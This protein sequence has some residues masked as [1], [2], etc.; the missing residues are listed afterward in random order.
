VKLKTYLIEYNT[1]KRTQPMA[2]F[3]AEKKEAYN[4]WAR[5]TD[6]AMPGDS[7]TLKKNGSTIASVNRGEKRGGDS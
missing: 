2:F 1:G 3:F 4:A 6:T 5:F 7:L